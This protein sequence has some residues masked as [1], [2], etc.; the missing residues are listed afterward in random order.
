MPKNQP[1]LALATE[2]PG[3]GRSDAQA[4]EGRDERPPLLAQ[5]QLRPRNGFAE[6]VAT[7]AGGGSLSATVHNTGLAPSFVGFVE[8]YAVVSRLQS[9]GR[10]LVVFDEKAQPRPHWRPVAR[11]EVLAPDAMVAD[12]PA[13]EPG[14]QVK[15]SPD[16][17]KNPESFVA[18]ESTPH[19]SRLL[20][21]TPVGALSPG[22]SVDLKVI[23]PAVTIA[24]EV[25]GVWSWCLVLRSFDLLQAPPRPIL[26][27][28]P[29]QA[30]FNTTLVCLHNLTSRER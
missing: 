13:G 6:A 25:D 18:P 2:T 5:L 19:R 20:S 29:A 17:A 16:D 7:A 21:R 11:G 4:R 1:H 30:F 22:E 15:V 3:H 8:A 9:L 14:T 27:P 26:I 28:I 12:L 24:M 23:V 10:R